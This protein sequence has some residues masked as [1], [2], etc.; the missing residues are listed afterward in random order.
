MHPRRYLPYKIYIHYIDE[1]FLQK[2]RLSLITTQTSTDSNDIHNDGPLSGSFHGT[3][4]TK[5]S[6]QNT[7]R[8]VDGAAS[9]EQN[10]SSFE[11][12]YNRSSSIGGEERLTGRKEIARTLALDRTNDAVYTA[13]TNVVK[14][15]MSLSQG[16]E[17]SAAIEYLDLVR[18]VGIELRAL[19]SSVDTLAS[20]FPPQAHK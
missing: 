13:T 20:I 11:R 18:N 2:K 8:Y 10:S 6:P 3:S 4:N 17:K 12:N 9:D 15:I 16:V 1:L 5:F 14:A 7:M 19:L